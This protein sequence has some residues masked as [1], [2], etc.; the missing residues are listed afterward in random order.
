MS[1]LALLA[2]A[3]ALAQ[4]ESSEFIEM[5]DSLIRDHNY[6]AASNP[7]TVVKTDDPRINVEAVA[8]LLGSFHGYF[9]EF[10]SDR[11]TIR[12]A[13][14]RSRLYL[15]YSRFKYKQLHEG[16]PPGTMEFVGHYTA[17]HDLIALHTDT[18]GLANLPDLLLHEAAHRLIQVR[19]YGEDYL[20]SPWVSEGLAS[21]FGHTLRDRSGKF[22]TGRIGGKGATFFKG[23]KPDTRGSAHYV[24]KEYRRA[25]KKGDTR[26]LDELL[27]ADGGFY[28]Q[29]G[30][31]E[32]YAASWLLVHYLL[33]ADN[34]AHASSFARYLEHEAEG[35]QGPEVFF[36]DIEMTPAALSES[37]EDYVLSLKAR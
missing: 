33:H 1:I 28:V 32:R 25:V 29:G 3:G 12:D 20:P 8:D 26:P 13:P 15:F 9:E 35:E 23:V 37:F 21:Y 11:L 19:L 4:D 16:I 30:E 36:E 14:D 18:V 7:Y 24:L 10:W 31:A 34:G 17:Y 22:S 27:E 2:A 5:V 6:T